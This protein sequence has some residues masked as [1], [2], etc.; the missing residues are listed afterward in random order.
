[1][2]FWGLYSPRFGIVLSNWGV[3][4]FSLYLSTQLPNPAVVKI[5]LISYT[6]IKGA[7]KRGSN[8]LWPIF[9]SGSSRGNWVEQGHQL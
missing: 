8:G 9:C 4:F 2:E 5:Y 1:M 7:D 3:K 6:Y